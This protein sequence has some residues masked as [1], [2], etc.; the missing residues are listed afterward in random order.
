MPRARDMRPAASAAVEACNGYDPQ[1]SGALR[2]FPQTGRID[3]H[4][5]R[6]DPIRPNFFIR[7]ALDFDKLGQRKFSRLH[8]D[9]R[10]LIAQMKAQ[11]GDAKAFRQHG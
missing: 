1:R 2:C 5:R 7:G 4:R 8:I 11:S 6:H 10:R 3:L 9:R